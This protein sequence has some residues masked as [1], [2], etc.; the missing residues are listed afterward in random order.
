MTQ[1]I[2]ARTLVILS[3]LGEIENQCGWGLMQMEVLRSRIPGLT[4]DI[5]KEKWKKWERNRFE[6]F[7]AIQAFLTCAGIVD[8]LVTGRGP[9][10]P[11]GLVGVSDEERYQIRRELRIGEDFEVGG[12]P[13]RNSLVHIEERLVP[14][15]RPGGLRGDFGVFRISTQNSTALS[16]TMRAFDRETFQFG[17]VG[18]VCSL[19]DIE[20]SLVKLLKKATAAHN[21]ILSEINEGAN[22]LPGNKA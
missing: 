7:G 20:L 13:Q 14:W 6:L 8:S 3:V 19:R 10:R 15:S 5:T 16:Q 9:P 4:R 12:R 17:V 2:D 18:Q 11:K 1:D 21:R 22:R